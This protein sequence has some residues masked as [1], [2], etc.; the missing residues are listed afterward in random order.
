M[1]SSHLNTRST[2]VIGAW[3]EDVQST[4][5]QAHQ[6]PTSNS[7]K[8]SRSLNPYQFSA[9]KRFALATAEGNVMTSPKRYADH[10][11]EDPNTPKSRQ[12]LIYSDDT[13]RARPSQLYTTSLINNSIPDPLDRPAT[14]STDSATRSSKSKQFG[15]VSPVNGLGS[16]MMTENPVKRSDTISEV[17]SSGRNLNKELSRCKSAHGVLPSALK[18]CIVTECAQR[19][20]NCYRRTSSWRLARTIF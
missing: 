3:L 4:I 20:A 18:A 11:A 15:R 5:S 16:L 8:R 13:P 14:P 7:R 19:L 1:L 10:N 12:I 2:A 17:P 9:R 6:P